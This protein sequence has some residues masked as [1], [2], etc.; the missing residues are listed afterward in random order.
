LANANALEEPTHAP[1]MLPHANGCDSGAGADADSSSS[2]D[3]VD[4]MEL[5]S[6]GSAEVLA[7]PEAEVSS[8]TTTST[9]AHEAAI[10]VHQTA[11]VNLWE[12]AGAAGNWLDFGLAI[13]YLHT[14]GLEQGVL[15][16]VMALSATSNPG[17][18][19]SQTEFNVA[20]KLV[21]LA[22]CV[23]PC[24]ATLYSSPSRRPFC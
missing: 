2:G 19:M 20:M 10:G 4:T 11:E 24:F 6:T 1:A 17:Q 14:S 21:M 18:G 7:P 22:Q 16:T 23:A 12:E 15:D 13:A 5:T 8:T 9:P 3:S